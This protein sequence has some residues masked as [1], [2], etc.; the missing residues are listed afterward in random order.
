MV[1][2]KS[3]C[4][5]LCPWLLRDV[6]LPPGEPR[7]RE[8]LLPW[9]RVGLLVPTLDDFTLSP[10]NPLAEGSEPGPGSEGRLFAPGTGDLRTLWVVGRWLPGTTE[11]AGDGKQNVE[12]QASAGC[13]K[14]PTLWRDLCWSEPTVE[15]ASDEGRCG[16][17]RGQLPAF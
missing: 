5:I 4:C 16:R 12:A 3:G 6:R 7:G 14:G 10:F 9:C 8:G 17:S 1:R 13:T 15:G 2:G 11:L